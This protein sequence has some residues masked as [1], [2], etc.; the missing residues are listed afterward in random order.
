MRQKIIL[1]LFF[2]FMVLLVL[3]VFS[4]ENQP[5]AFKQCSSC[6]VSNNP[7]GN[8][9]R[10][11]TA[12]IT[13]LCSTNC[14]Q[15]IF[16]EGYMHPV[17]VRPRNVTIPDDM[18][19]S[20]SGELTCSTCHDVHGEYMTPYGASSHFLRRKES[21]KAFCKICHKSFDVARSGHKASLGEA[22]FRS[23]YMVAEMSQQIDPMSKNCISCHDGTFAS[24]PTIL[25]GRWVHE[26]S[27]VRHDLGSHPIGMD[28]EA[29]RFNRG[30]KTDLRPMTAVDRRIR[31]FNGRVG[32][33]SCHDPYSTLY[34][35]LVMSDEHS[36]L[37]L[38]CHMI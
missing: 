20:R 35:K 5:H 19:V 2:S 32:C 27:L 9:A 25:A 30:A 12:P 33:G 37:C 3:V 22:H 10:Q 15:K 29:T 8:Q 1:A 16:D 36:K 23:Q 26:K 4:L 18:P 13:F 28:Y 38:T 7:A 14:H 17:D 34:K 21:G 6:H 11:M 31:F 24:S